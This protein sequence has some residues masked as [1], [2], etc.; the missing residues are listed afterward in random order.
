VQ[1]KVEPPAGTT[2]IAG[3][4]RTRVE[5]LAGGGGAVEKSWLLRLAP[6][7]P[8]K[9]VVTAYAPAVGA[10]SKTVEAP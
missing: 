10:A 2:W 4:Q 1:I 6:G 5:P 7:G 8:R 9:I 3:S